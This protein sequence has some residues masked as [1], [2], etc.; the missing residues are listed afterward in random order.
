MRTLLCLSAILSLGVLTLAA[1]ESAP[2][3]LP[4]VVLLGDSIRLGYAPVVEKELVGKALVVSAKANGGDSANTVKH[5][6]EWVIRERPAVVHF[7]CGIHDTKK[8]KVSGK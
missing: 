1:A 3:Q 8:A 7:N 5:L 2:G 4:K 6:D